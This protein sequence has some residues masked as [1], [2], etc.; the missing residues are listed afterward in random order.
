M[1][2]NKTI[3]RKFSQT[4]VYAMVSAVCMAG[5]YVV[6]PARSDDVRWPSHEIKGRDY[7]LMLFETMACLEDFADEPFVQDSGTIVY[8][9][10]FYPLVKR[11]NPWG[12][13]GPGDKYTTQG[14]ET[15]KPGWL[16]ERM[17]RA[18]FEFCN[19]MGIGAVNSSHITAADIDYSGWDRFAEE[20]PETFLGVRF[21]EWDA[22]LLH[23]LDRH[24]APKRRLVGELGVFPCHRAEMRENFHRFWQYARVCAGG[25]MFGLSGST[26]FEHWG[27]EWGGSVSAIETSGNLEKPSRN[28]LMFARSAARQFNVPMLAYTAYFRLSWA[29][30]SRPD[31]CGAEAGIET[32]LAWRLHLQ[33]YYMGANLQSFESMPWGGAEKGPDGKVRLTPNGLELRDLYT[34]TR[35]PAGAR[36]EC[37]TPVLFLVDKAHGF[38]QLNEGGITGHKR[39]PFFG[40]FVPSP[41]D[42][43]TDYAMRTIS[44]RYGA[45]F[46]ASP[47]PHATDKSANM[48]NSPIGDIFDVFIA[49]SDVPGRGLRDDQLERYAVVMPLGEILWSNDLANRLKRYVARGGTL[50]LTGSQ[51]V[52]FAKD[53]EFIGDRF[54]KGKCSRD[55]IAV[56]DYGNGRVLVV[57]NPFME[58]K[59]KPWIVPEA[60]K[61]LLADI[62]ADVVPFPVRGECSFLYNRMPDGSWKA[63]VMNNSGTAKLGDEKNRPPDPKWTRTATLDLPAGA[64]FEEVLMGLKGRVETDGGVK[65]VSFDI[66]SGKVI[67]VN[68]KGIPR[69]G[70]LRTRPFKVEPVRHFADQVYTPHPV[71][72]KFVYDPALEP[73]RPPTP[74]VVFDWKNPTGGEKAV[75]TNCFLPAKWTLPRCTVEA[76][77]KW[78]GEPANSGHRSAAF[79]IGS[80]IG[81]EVNGSGHWQAYCFCWPFK[82][83]VEGPK[84]EPGRWTDL[85]LEYDRGC[86]RFFVDGVEYKDPS[87]GVL[88]SKCDDCRDLFYSRF[89]VAIGQMTHGWGHY[90]KGAVRSLRVTSKVNSQMTGK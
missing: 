65:R 2:V 5:N 15:I 14:P 85:K 75:V 86:V 6:D 21:N 83:S 24:D 39:G 36:G 87:R 28:Q 43:Y 7:W 35:S 25:R 1:P 90:F 54:L 82:T 44:P 73:P 80:Q 42:Y 20:Y 30:D 50:V 23:I 32:S 26:N 62:Q 68:V 55:E 61:R 64:E 58:Q 17:A 31:H 13:P 38:D 29:P 51:T 89:E 63:I 66:P 46:L 4:V 9:T 19:P 37:Y 10:P 47:L 11:K 56:N 71:Y 52:P 18:P 76:S 57:V 53:P 79:Y 48:R 41:A 84:A 49:N 74:E 22:A 12:L 72:D 40:S 88:Q 16:R 67:V 81:I 78:S 34:W 27:C 69:P 33:A 60:M 8:A 45:P 59:E 70:R 3:L 77:A